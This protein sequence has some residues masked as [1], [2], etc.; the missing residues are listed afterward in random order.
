MMHSDLA[1]AVV[2]VCE[3]C[4]STLAGRG[5]SVSAVRDGDKAE[6]QY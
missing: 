6:F 3:E 2:E 4:L 5:L 1:H